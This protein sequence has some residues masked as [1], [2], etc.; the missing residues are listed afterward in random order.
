MPE[1]APVLSEQIEDEVKLAVP[2]VFVLPPLVPAPPDGAVVET[3][4]GALAEAVVGP[5]RS[6]RATYHD[7]PDL[8]LARG[9]AT[10]RHRTGEGRP[11]WTLKLPTGRSGE[12]LE[13][14]VAAPATAMPAEIRALVTA[15]VREAELAEVVRLTTR[16]DTW[17]LRDAADEELGEL[18][19]DLVSV[20]SAG[21]VVARFRE[22]EVERRGI[23]DADLDSLVHRLVDAGAVPGVFTS[24]LARALGPRAS[25]APDVPPASK[26]RRGDPAAALVAEAVRDG[27]RRLLSEDPR[28]RLGRDDAVHQLRVACRRLRSDLATFAP[29]L[30]PA[31]VDDVRTELAWLADRLGAARDLEVLRERLAATFRV[32]PLA[33]LDDAA[34]ARLDALLADREQGALEQAGRALTEPRYVELLTAVVTLAADP[35]TTQ[36]A[37]E[38]ASTVLPA[39]VGAV[40]TDLDAAVERLSLRA[41]DVRWHKARI[42]AKRARYAAEAAA[43]ALGDQAAATGRAMAAVQSV[44]GDHQDAAVAADAVLAVA[45]AHPDDPVLVLL[46]GRLAERERAAVRDARARFGP[47]WKAAGKASVR[48]WLP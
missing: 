25:A 2:A 38:P 6:L 39:V 42:R 31:S 20:L 48:R 34:F 9:G 8:R 32:D 12:R 14:S 5:R 11:T 22:L 43:V 17:S 13:L 3:V 7:T 37:Q 4:E 16:R 15:Q 41:S 40:V 21:K 10:L 46:C 23:S 1:A 24:K 35:P 19:D 26:V 47:V 44:L 29:L 18:V 45:Q 36:A 33:P 30:V 28:L 27:V